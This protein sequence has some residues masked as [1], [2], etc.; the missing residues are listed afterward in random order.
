LN[1]FFWFLKGGKFTDF[2]ED[3]YKHI[4][5][6]FISPLLIEMFLPFI[7]HTIRYMYWW[8]KRL[9]DRNFKRNKHLTKQKTALGY[10]NLYSGPEIE[11]FEKYPWLLNLAFLAMFYGFMMPYFFLAVLICVI[12]SYIVDRYTIV[13]FYRKSPSY[14]ITI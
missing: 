1:S 11:Y 14:N 13:Y 4:A 12:T 10:A 9:L 3:W 8:I 5:Y 7:E 6:Y 2:N